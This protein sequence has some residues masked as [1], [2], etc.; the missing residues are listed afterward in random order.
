MVYKFPYIRLARTTCRL[1]LYQTAVTCLAVPTVAAMTYAGTV[2]QSA[3]ITT[4]GVNI[5]AIMM[6]GVMG[7]IFRKLVGH[8]Y[9]SKN[10]MQVKI[11]HLT[12]FGGRCDLIVPADDLVPLCE[13]P[14][15]ATDVY[16]RMKRYSDDGSG[17]GGFGMILCLR[18]GGV[19]DPAVF[20]RV[21]GVVE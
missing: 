4:I 5:I 20:E 18:F 9:V 17:G 1:K 16:V 19:L 21:F 6:L 12:F 3:L 11:S 15:S 10:E 7:E 13:L 8:L 14:D 2:T